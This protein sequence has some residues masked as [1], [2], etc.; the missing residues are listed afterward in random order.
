MTAKIRTLFLSHIK[1]TNYL[2][3]KHGTFNL[4]QKHAIITISS[5]VISFLV[6]EETAVA[7]HYKEE[8]HHILSGSYGLVLMY[9]QAPFPISFKE[10]RRKKE[11]LAN[12]SQCQPKVVPGR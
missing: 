9:F 5:Y 12:L 8:L 7:I 11:H 3:L 4:R 6:I 10:M 1:I 2:T